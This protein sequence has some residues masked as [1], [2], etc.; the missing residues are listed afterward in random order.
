MNIWPFSYF[1]RRKAKQMW[2]EWINSLPHVTEEQSKGMTCVH[3]VG[4]TLVIPEGR[5]VEE[6]HYGK[7]INNIQVSGIPPLHGDVTVKPR[8]RGYGTCL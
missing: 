1:K 3:V 4:K 5:A 6:V 8:R 2:E 7:V